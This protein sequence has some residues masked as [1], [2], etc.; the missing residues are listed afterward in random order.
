MLCIVPIYGAC[1]WQCSRGW[2][3]VQGE[4][5]WEALIAVDVLWERRGA[6]S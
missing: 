3:G 5:V 6:K 1:P 4:L 2:N